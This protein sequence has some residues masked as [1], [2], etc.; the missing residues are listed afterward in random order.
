MRGE[1]AIESEGE[2]EG[3]REGFSECERV[4]MRESVGE[5]ER[6]REINKE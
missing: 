1:R 6:T 2:E 5:K 3:V 4:M